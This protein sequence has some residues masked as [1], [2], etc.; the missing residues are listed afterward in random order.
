[1]M[2]KYAHVGDLVKTAV[3]LIRV[4]RTTRNI[5]QFGEFDLVQTAETIWSPSRKH[6]GHV[7]GWDFS[8]HETAIR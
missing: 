4:S 3:Q 8:G 2:T 7:L 1:M 6:G 5:A